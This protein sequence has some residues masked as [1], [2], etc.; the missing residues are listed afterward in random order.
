MQ[1]ERAVR[2]RANLLEVSVGKNATNG[3]SSDTEV[4]VPTT[5]PT[6]SPSSAIPLTTVTPVG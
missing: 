4:N 1:N 6:G 3:G 2:I 5:M